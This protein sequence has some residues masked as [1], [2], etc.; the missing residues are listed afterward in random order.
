MFLELDG[1]YNLAS[2]LCGVSIRLCQTLGLH[3]KSPPDF[4][5]GPDEVKFRSQLWWTA[6]RL[7]T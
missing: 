4:D 6:F 3:R 2:V 1:Q 7:E 5:L